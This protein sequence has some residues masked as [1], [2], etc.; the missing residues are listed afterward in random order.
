MTFFV[1]RHYIEN[2]FLMSW[3]AILQTDVGNIMLNSRFLIHSLSGK[4]ILQEKECSFQ[5]VGIDSR[6]EL[7]SR[8]F[9]AVKGKNFDGH[10]F[11]LSALDKGAKAFVV[12]DLEKSRFLLKN[13][14][15]SLILVPDT[16]RAL[17]ELA[18]AWRKK[19][20]FR[21]TAITGSNGKTTTCCFTKS[22]LSDL[23]PF[24]SPKSYNN[25]IGVSLSL[26]RVKQKSA[27]VI[28]EI[29]TSQ[30]GEIA[31]LTRLSQPDVSAVTMVG[32]SHLEGLKS[33]SGV[34]EEKKDIYL[35]SPK[36]CWIFNKDNIWVKKM[37]RELGRNRLSSL[38]SFDKKAKTETE[39]GIKNQPDLSLNR[40]GR[41]GVL[42]FSSHLKNVDVRLNFDQR[43]KKHSLIR[44]R[45]GDFESSAK[46]G[47]SGRENLENLMCASAI[48]L[49]MGLEPERIWKRLSDCR[50]PEGRQELCVLKEQ[51]ISFYFDAYNANPSSMAFFLKSCERA[52]AGRNRILIL[53]DMKELGK[54]TEKYH[55]ELAGN[56][57]LLS[58]KMVF[59]IGDNSSLIEEELKRKGYKGFFKGFTA[60]SP[61][62][63]SFLKKNWKK[64][65]F[66]GIK[67]SRSLALEN[68]FFE[69]SGNR[70]L[71]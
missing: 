49:A 37:W 57:T 1:K 51:N 59:F 31:F 56:E 65:D 16:V 25:S 7:R 42:S 53:G 4:Q 52:C 38:S 66:I 11:L 47:V 2:D 41:A 10:D 5:G 24:A 27:V 55:K 36:A 60:Y 44:G 39:K 28:Q 61:E 14:N 62:L 68:L 71:S 12:S 8:I 13:Q 45:I 54:D 21:L 46:V 19:Q 58:S 17:T 32:A 50:V 33:L 22:I 48:G 6:K 69:L 43:D 63:A 3:G 15:I 64:G 26:L 9:F 23:R 40:R 70:V 30:P 29:G 18:G 35:N 67:A 34:A 20:K